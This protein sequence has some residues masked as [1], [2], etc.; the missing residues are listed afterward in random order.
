MN[1]PI[2]A[3]PTW[4]DRQGRGPQ[5]SF[6]DVARYVAAAENT[7]DLGW[8]H[9]HYIATMWAESSFYAWA[10]PMVWKPDDAAH[11]SVDRGI[12]ALNSHWWDWVDDALAY[13]PP[14]AI[15]VTVH[16]ISDRARDG[17][18][19]AKP[20]DWRPLLDWQWHAYGTQRY[21]DAMPLARSAVNEVRRSAGLP[22]V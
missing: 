5:L 11:L 18:K 20:W 4:E 19:G 15:R 13:D 2:D 12:C 14:H 21:I 16:W 17:V 6:D 10:R 8:R 7:V 22:A 3:D 1:W 9:V